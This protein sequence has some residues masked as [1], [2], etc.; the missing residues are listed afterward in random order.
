MLNEE[1][2]RKILEITNERKSVSLIELAK[3]LNASESTI[4][5]DLNELHKNKLL[6]KV[7][8]GAISLNDI[9]TQ[10]EPVLQ[11]QDL[12]TGSKR[13]IARYGASLVKDNDVVY[14]DAGTTTGEMLPYLRNTHAV[15]ITNCASHAHI[16][17][18]YGHEVHLACG[19]LKAKTDALVGSDTYRYIEQLN[20]TIGFFGSNGISME[21]GFTTPDPQEGEIK[22]IA[23]DHCRERYVL[24]DPSK[25]DVISTYSFAAIDK[26]FII[27][28]SAAPKPYKDLHNTIIAD[29]V[30][31]V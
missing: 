20:F 12:N 15:Y 21:E 18:N 25:F 14:I 31:I 26:G 22:R 9:L 19:I 17:A 2:K 13:L 23:Y 5:R 4:R 28:D 29:L 27:T 7:H 30:D 24:A 3:L 11:R 8:G 6:K 16:L 1:R 10:D